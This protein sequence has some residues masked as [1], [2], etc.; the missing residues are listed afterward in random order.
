MEHLGIQRMEQ[1]T[2]SLSWPKLPK[3]RLSRRMW[4]ALV[5]RC[6]LVAV[7]GSTLLV[8]A[9]AQDPLP[10]KEPLKVKFSEVFDATTGER[11]S[12]QEWID[13]ALA[14]S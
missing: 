6:A 10:P 1:S 9:V 14:N 11:V 13:R 8:L 7:A 12:R 3:V 2:Q 4:V 5:G